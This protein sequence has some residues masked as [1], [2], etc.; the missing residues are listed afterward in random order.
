MKIVLGTRGSR[1][2]LVQSS[3]VASLLAAAGAEVKIRTI[4]T[5]GDSPNVVLTEVGGKGVFVKEIDEAL[6]SGEIDIAVHSMKDVPAKLHVGITIAAVPPREDARD[7]FISE[8]VSKLSELPKG[9]C[10]GTSSPRRRAQLLKLRPDL[11]VVPFRG[12]V[13]TRLR[14]L[15]DGEVDALILASAGLSRLSIS[16]VITELLSIDKMV[17]AIGQGA[18]AITVCSDNRELGQFVSKVCHHEVSG[19]AALAE[20][21][22]LKAVGGDCY[23]PLAAH[24][25][26]KSSGIIMMVSFMTTSDESHS[27]TLHDSGPVDEAAKIGARLGEKMIE[28]LRPILK[29]Y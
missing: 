21:S 10:V 6:L 13:E 7:A 16:N 29:P 9:A 14:K 3:Y 2:A 25:E 1:L 28:K 18:L 12:N 20:R 15:K 17:P 23:T 27:I 5:T 22:L 19:I 4:T 24:A 11:K 26:I 8:K